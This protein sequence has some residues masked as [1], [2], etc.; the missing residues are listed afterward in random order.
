MEQRITLDRLGVGQQCT[1]EEIQLTGALGRRLLD[2]GLIAGTQVACRQRA[3][4]GDP[5]AF[6]LRGA[7]IAL[8][9][10]DARQIIG[11]LEG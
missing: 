5:L 6:E 1:V 11:R 7:V 2:L 4:R 8:R 9:A 3:P 10:A